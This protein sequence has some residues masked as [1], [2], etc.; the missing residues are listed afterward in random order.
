MH[1][2][3]E[4]WFKKLVTVLAT[5][6]SVTEASKKVTLERVPC[7]QYPIQ[8]QKDKNA[9]QALL[10]LD[11]KVNAINPVYAKKLG[12]CVRQTDVGAQK[13]DGSHLDSFGIVITGFSLQNKLGKV[14]FFQETFVVADTRMEV[15]LRML[16]LTLSNTDIRFVK[17]ELVWKTYSAAKALPIT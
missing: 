1:Q 4:R 11:S 6:A 5:S 7:I 16:F 9:I 8:L 14:R 3:Q 13:I 15:V 10:D 17:G 2:A 12:L